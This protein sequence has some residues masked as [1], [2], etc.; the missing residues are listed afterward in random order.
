MFREGCV[1]FVDLKILDDERALVIANGF[2]TAL[3]TL[4]AQYY[5]AIA[6]CTEDASNGNSVLNQLH[7][8]SLPRQTG[9]SIIRI[10]CVAYTTNIVLCDF[11]RSLGTVDSRHPCLGH[12]RIGNHRFQ[13][14]V[15]EASSELTYLTTKPFT[16]TLCYGKRFYS[17]HKI[18]KRTSVK[19]L[20][21]SRSTSLVCRI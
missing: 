14:S 18:D 15:A 20:A 1:R 4:A 8:F 16:C 7:T 17:F 19:L 3:S 2:V 9:L 6:T 21:G 11:C 5:V 12:Q 10:L 13:L